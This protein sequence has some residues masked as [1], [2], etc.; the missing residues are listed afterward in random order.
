MIRPSLV[1]LRT[2]QVVLAAVWFANGVAKL[3]IAAWF[4]NSGVKTMAVFKIMRLTSKFGVLHWERSVT[5]VVHGSRVNSVGLSSQ[6]KR[7]QLCSLRH[8]LMG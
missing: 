4:G 1:V 5:D 2:G 3:I 6:S 8:S 7:I